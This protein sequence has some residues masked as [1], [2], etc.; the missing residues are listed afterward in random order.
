MNIYEDN[1]LA[2]FPFLCIVLVVLLTK[3]SIVK[4][5]SLVFAYKGAGKTARIIIGI[6]NCMY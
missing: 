1:M 6:L 4:F 2:V 3:S 5:S